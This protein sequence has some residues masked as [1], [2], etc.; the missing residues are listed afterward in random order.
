MYDKKSP[1]FAIKY[2][3][4]ELMGLRHTLPSEERESYLI[5]NFNVP[6]VRE[7]LYLLNDILGVKVIVCM[8]TFTYE[9]K[10]SQI[11]KFLSAKE[12]NFFLK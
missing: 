4:M 8:I 7:N 10:M 5:S 11:L 9:I 6:S 3:L 12:N 1:F 2:F